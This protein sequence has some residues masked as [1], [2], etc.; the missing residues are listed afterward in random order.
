MSTPNS[1]DTSSDKTKT[2]GVE[3]PEG[4]FRAIARIRRHLEGVPSDEVGIGD[5]AA[6][7]RSGSSTYLLA[8][9]L[10]VAGVHAD[11]ELIGLDDLGWRAMTASV[12]DMAAMGAR[13]SR[14]VVAVAGP[15]STDLDRLY[16]GIGAAS[17]AYDCL[18]VGGDLANAVQ[19]VVAVTVSGELPAGSEPVLRRGAR[20]G[21]LVFVTGPLGAA[22]A[23]LRHLRKRTSDAPQ[24]LFDAHRRPRARVA[25]GAAARVAGATAMIDVSDGFGADLGHLADASQVG[26]LLDDVPVFPGATREEAIAGGDDY[27]L[28]FSAPLR[29]R[30]LE[31][32]ECRD[33]RPPLCVGVCVGDA[34]RRMLGDLPLPA[35]GWEHSWL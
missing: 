29:R 17:G 26:F 25:E 13:P 9:D 18:V 35:R 24:A 22:A 6:V 4:E 30:V 10:T 11:L 27:E 8:T 20:P 2:G 23:G 7:V 33:L 32:F 15:S 28:V 34:Q 3:H 19:V 14:A 12:S 21:D 16:E 5:D 31:V 1:G